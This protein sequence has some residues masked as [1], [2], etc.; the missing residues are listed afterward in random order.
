M[1]PRTFV[2]RDDAIR[3][4]AQDYVGGLPIA[5]HP[6]EVVV[7]PHRTRRTLDQ[8]ALL[9]ALLDDV[10]TQ[11]DWYGQKLTREDWKTMFSA[12]LKKQRAVPGIDGGFVIL[13]GSTSTL[14]VSEFSDLIDLIYAFGAERDVQFNG[15]REAA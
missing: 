1:S 10:A 3:A 9:W 4:R 7:R 5:E 12:S 2:L 6:L 15:K 13:G 11:V 8:N 14:T